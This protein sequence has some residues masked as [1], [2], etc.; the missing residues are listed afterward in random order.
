MSPTYGW[1]EVV[2]CLCGGITAVPYW[3]EDGNPVLHDTEQ[4]VIDELEEDG[5][6]VD[7][8][9]HWP[10]FVAWEADG[11]KFWLADQRTRELI[12]PIPDGR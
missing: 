8:S 2:D 11:R 7:L 3:D 6:E 4:S 10:E 9:D 5:E 12:R 1:I